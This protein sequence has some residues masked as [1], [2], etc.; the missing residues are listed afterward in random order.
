MPEFLNKQ[1][2]IS[3][4]K[5]HIISDNDWE[6]YMIDNYRCFEDILANMGGE[7]RKIYRENYYKEPGNVLMK[8]HVTF[9]EFKD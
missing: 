7:L 6:Y 5:F 4:E 2:E 8:I 3:F 1:G 9:E